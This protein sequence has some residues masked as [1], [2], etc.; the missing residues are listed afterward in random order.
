[1]QTGWQVIKGQDNKFLSHDAA[2]YVLISYLSY[3]RTVYLDAFTGI[4]AASGHIVVRDDPTC[5]QSACALAPGPYKLQEKLQNKFHPSWKLLQ[6]LF[7]LSFFVFNLSFY[8][9]MSWDFWTSVELL[10]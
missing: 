9:F 4:K 5:A 6:A 7:T 1:M 3:S 10:K 8:S 2:Q